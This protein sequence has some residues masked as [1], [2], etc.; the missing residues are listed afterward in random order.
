[1]AFRPRILGAM[2]RSLRLLVLI[3]IALGAAA[4]ADDETPLF[5]GHETI[6][7]EAGQ[8]AAFRWHP[9]RRG[10]SVETRPTGPNPGFR[11]SRSEAA[12]FGSSAA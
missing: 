2:K 3:P 11:A 8:H 12:L 6:T 1:M 4:L 7:L 9:D 10:F 5:S